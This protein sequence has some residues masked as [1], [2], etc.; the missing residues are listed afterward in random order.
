TFVNTFGFAA[1]KY[2]GIVTGNGDDAY[3]LY[4]GG[5][6]TSGTLSDIYGVVDQD[7]TGMPWEYLDGRAVRNPGIF[8]PNTTWT[9]SEWTITL[10][11]E[12]GGTN[13][14]VHILVGE[15]EN[16]LAQTISIYPNPSNGE[17]NV[18]VPEGTWIMSVYAVSGQLMYREKIEG[19][20]SFNAG[21]PS[22]LYLMKFENGN[23]QYSTRI[24][25]K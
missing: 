12:S 7:G 16:G 18:V 6:Q 17:F 2:S 9:A 15:T 14:G 11:T 13:P 4:F 21:I 10:G 3:F 22:G 23:S 8:H 1:D 25:V 24:L 20:T 5:N 19:S